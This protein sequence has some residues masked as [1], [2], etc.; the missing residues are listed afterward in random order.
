MTVV[1]AGSTAIAPDFVRALGVVVLAGLAA[2]A[3]VAPRTRV[4][5]ICVL[6]ALVLTPLLLVMEIWKTPQ[7]S[8]ARERPLV[9]THDHD[10]IAALELDLDYAPE[11][12]PRA[13]IDARPRG[14]LAEPGR[15]DP[16]QRA[17][18]APWH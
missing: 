11:H 6:A 18:R 2:A 1:A 13:R 4:R 10:L 9:G 17:C 7:L 12:H 8:F 5:A 14:R 15:V 3:M 16:P